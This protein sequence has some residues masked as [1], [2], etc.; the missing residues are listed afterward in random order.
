MM[1][2]GLAFLLFLGACGADLSV[3]ALESAVTAPPELAVPDDHHVVADHRAIGF[4]IYECREGSWAL[5]S[6]AAILLGDDGALVA[7]HYGGIDAGLPAGP[8]WQSSLDG[9]RVHA[10]RPISVPNPGAIPLLRLEAL[11][12]A[13]AGI[14][15]DVSHVQRLET[16]GG[17]APTG[18]C[19]RPNARAYIPYAA[20]YVF[21]AASLPRPEIPETIAVPEGH[22]VARVGHATG[23]QIYECTPAATWGLRAPAA[24]LADE[25]GDFA[26]HYGGIDAGLPAGPYWESLRDGSRV[27]AG[28][29]LA[30]PSPG[31][32]ALLR[33]TALDTAGNGIFSRVSYIHRLATSGG[34][35]P[36]GSCTPG[37]RVEIPYEAD[38]Y[39]YVPAS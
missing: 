21:W 32:I 11:D 18:S 33:L 17:L 15:A 1:R 37:A 39:F 5:R 6:P 30:A 22:D 7:I 16:V 34:V 24:S 23:V 29:A 28:A 9:S 26:I 35:A 14:F 25:S 27:H 3:D 13:G 12:T 20:T 10:G 4:Q 19:R 36:T 8:Y 2:T 31:T 38:Y